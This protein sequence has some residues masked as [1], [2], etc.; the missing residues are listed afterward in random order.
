MPNVAMLGAS[1][2]MGRVIVPLLHDS[3]EF[4]LTGALAAAGDP[5]LGLDA[6]TLSGIAPLGVAITDDPARALD[7]AAVAIDFTRPAASGENA[8]GCRDL[9]CALVVGTTGHDAVQRA[10]LEAVTDR[11]PVV[12]APNMSVGVNLLFRLAELAARALGPDYD[13]EIFEA[14]HR[15]KV[16]APS[17]TALGLGHAAA[18]GSTNWPSMPATGRA[19]F[20]SPAGSASA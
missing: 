15:N 17:G 19:G 18:A 13:I 3:G 11:I 1:G 4:R 2:R 16:D 10:A 14:H 5:G 20:A 9:G 7:G 6:G 8:R 12:L